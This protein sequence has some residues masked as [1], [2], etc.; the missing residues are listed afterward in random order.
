MPQDHLDNPDAETPK[1]HPDNRQG[2]EAGNQ[3]AQQE[4]E[5]AFNKAADGAP[6]NAGAPSVAGSTDY[7]VGDVSGEFV[8]VTQAN[9]VNQKFNKLVINLNVNTN[10]ADTLDSVGS[11]LDAAGEL[12]T[13]TK[14]LL[15]KAKRIL[16]R[17]SLPGAGLVKPREHQPK[18]GETPS[19]ETDQE[20][21]RWTDEELSGWY[22]DLQESER[23]FVQ[24]VAVLHGAPRHEII[25]VS[26]EIF[27]SAKQETSQRVSTSEVLYKRT[28]TA[29]RTLHDVARIFWEDADASGLSSFNLRILRF[30]GETEVVDWTRGDQSGKGFFDLI[31]EWPTTLPGEGAW[32][33]ARALGVMWEED[34]ERLRREVDRWVNSKDPLDWTSAAAL[35]DGAHE[36]ERFKASDKDADSKSP[37]LRWISDW[38]AAANNNDRIGPGCAAA[39]AYGLIGRQYPQIALEGLDRLLGFPRHRVNGEIRLSLSILSAGLESYLMMAASGRLRAVLMYL[40][41][42]AESLVH[43]PVIAQDVRQRRGNEMRRD[44]RLFGVFTAFFLLVAVSNAGTGKK[45][46]ASYSRTQP[47]PDPLPFPDEEGRDVLLLALLTQGSSGFYWRKSLTYLL[48][49]ALLD[50]NPV[51]VTQVLR[52]WGHII[53]RL[54]DQEQPDI[55]NAYT[56][57]LV[58][59]G[60]LARVWCD[61]LKPLKSHPSAGIEAYCRQLKFWQYGKSKDEPPLAGLSRKVLARLGCQPGESRSQASYHPPA[62]R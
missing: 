33:A 35:L 37:I 14:A 19:P 60:K 56:T 62:M 32:R 25:D 24:A 47:L 57:F 21:A 40:A 2:N 49:A 22:E 31:K 29:V 5:R 23:S 16:E 42:V 61:D 34:T 6:G 1:N 17:P 44:I 54:E 12:D 41:T 13:N 27:A 9:E 58:D 20:L 36:L 10:I 11:T 30:I 46:S 53:V 8:S 39:Y 45:E 43:R 51:A 52:R 15:E 7:T 4:F 50:G 59:L 55:L 48:C 3:Q 38:V 26:R 28:H 18:D